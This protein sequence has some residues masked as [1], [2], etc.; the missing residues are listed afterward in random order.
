MTYF[1]VWTIMISCI[2]RI[3]VPSILNSA[4][5]RSEPSDWYPAKT[6][7][8]N[9]VG[10]HETWFD[11][12]A[13]FVGQNLYKT[14]LLYGNIQYICSPIQL[15]LVQFH[16]VCSLKNPHNLLRMKQMINK[17]MLG[18]YNTENNLK[19]FSRVQHSHSFQEKMDHLV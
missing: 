14:P 19:T 12:E 6:G 8:R 10:L 13:D 5:H 15:D 3:V 9:H 16:F 11:E 18:Q 17:Y 4:F 1:V 7:W 2:S